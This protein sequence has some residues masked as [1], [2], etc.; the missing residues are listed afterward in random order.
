MGPSIVVA[1]LLWRLGTSTP[2]SGADL[3]ARPPRRSR[4]VTPLVRALPPASS[5]R[6]RPGLHRS[7]RRPQQF[8]VLSLDGAGLRGRL[9]R[10]ADRCRADA[11]SSIGACSAGW[12]SA[13]RWSASPRSPPRSCRRRFRPRTSGRRRRRTLSAERPRDARRGRRVRVG[14]AA[15]ATARTGVLL[16]QLGRTSLF[17]YWIHVELVY[18]LIS[19]PLHRGTDAAAGVR[20]I[21]RVLRP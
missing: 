5:A 18:G 9:R 12:R 4:F 2:G 11:G 13:G 10:R 19:R 3:R 15:G 1:A 16:V 21:R 6:R 17:I 7:G 14:P 20:R 8:R